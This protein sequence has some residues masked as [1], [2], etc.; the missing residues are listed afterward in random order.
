MNRF[1]RKKQDFL[2]TGIGYVIIPSDVDRN[3]FISTCMSTESVSIFTEEGGIFHNVKVPSS[4]LQQIDFPD[5]NVV[6][7]GSA[8]LYVS[9]SKQGIPIVTQILS[10]GDEARLLKYKEWRL[11]RNLNN[12]SAL[13]S[14]R[15]DKG[16]IVMAVNSEESGGGNILISVRQVSGN[17]NLIMDVQGDGSFNMRDLK[18]NLTEL[19]QIDNKN[20]YIQ[21]TESIYL[22]KESLEWGVMGETLK[23][24]LEDLMT[25]L[26]NAKV[27]T[28]IGPQPFMPPTP[29]EIGKWKVKLSDI[30][31]DLVKV[32]KKE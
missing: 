32:G 2:P 27:L 25:I 28:Q 13:L 20:T 12:N 30:L 31:S 6:V 8:V 26:T 17:G 9:H 19:L 11:H 5:G 15:G 10:K 24:M 23:S 7:L 4:V 3:Q 16:D 1:Q 18:I 29:I 21:S 14:G 22:G